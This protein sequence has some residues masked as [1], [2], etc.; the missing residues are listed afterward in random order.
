MNSY[1]LTIHRVISCHESTQLP[2]LLSYY[3]LILQK[4]DDQF[5]NLRHSKIGYISITILLIIR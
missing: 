2:Y 4:V 1:Q 3:K 5:S